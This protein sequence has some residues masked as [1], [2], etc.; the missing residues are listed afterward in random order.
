MLQNARVRMGISTAYV[1][2]AEFGRYL[3]ELGTFGFL[4]VWTAKLGLMVALV[5]AYRLLKRAG[6]RGAATASL[7][8]AVLT[9]AGNSD[10]RPHLAGALLH[11]LRIHSG[12][13]PFG[14]A[15]AG[16][17]R[18]GT[19]ADA[20]RC[21]GRA[22]TSLHGACS[23]RDADVQGSHLLN[24]TEVEG[25]ACLGSV[26]L[27]CPSDHGPLRVTAGVL[28]CPSQ[29][30]YP[31]V[32]GIAVLLSGD[33]PDSHPYFEESRRAARGDQPREPA[34]AGADEVDPFVQ[35]EIVKT[36][37]LLYQGVLGGLRRYPIP[38]IPLPDTTDG[39]RLLDIGCNWG[40]WSIAASRRGYRAIGIDPGIAAVQAAYRASR[41]LGQSPG[42][43]VGDGRSLPFPD[44]TVRRGVF[45]L[46]AA[47][48]LEGG[49]EGEH[50]RGRARDQ[51]RRPGPHPAR[52][53][54]GCPPALQPGPRYI[55]AGTGLV[56]GPAL[57]ARGRC[58]RR[59]A[60]SSVRR[61]C[62]P[63]DSSR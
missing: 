41:A 11:W 23:A 56:P 46:R 58:C 54:A 3:V 7:S 34:G 12:R 63:T 15:G 4:V 52:E 38:E 31:L 2:E 22:M 26:P 14:D 55:A 60:S 20:D 36:N 49:R 10:L 8:Y 16:G 42:F 24:V 35:Q 61:A 40:R 9:M 32:G 17:G 19:R 37:G 43:V 45:V 28:R 53:P 57:D 62:R 21:A 51:T 50:P 25:R 59:S 30:D 44:Q 47:A 48:L 33:R 6:R 39:L 5:R 13:G 27:A 1:Q 29:H 18:T